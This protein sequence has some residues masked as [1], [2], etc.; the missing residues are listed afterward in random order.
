MGGLSIVGATIE[1]DSQKP[2]GIAIRCPESQLI[3]A[4]EN[5]E[6]RDS[7]ITALKS[8]ADSHILPAN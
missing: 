3:L 2:Y 7:W 1:K 4:A 5:D 8:A 6:D